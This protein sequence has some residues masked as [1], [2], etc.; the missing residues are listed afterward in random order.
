MIEWFFFD[1]EAAYALIGHG[2]IPLFKE[3]GMF[4]NFL[5]IVK[6]TYIAGVIYFELFVYGEIVNIY[7]EIFL[8]CEL[9]ETYI[10]PFLSCCIGHIRR[11]AYFR[12][13]ECFLFFV[14][15][16]VTACALL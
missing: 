5:L 3:R 16:C 9:A 11:G 12:L 8:Y 7:F 15:L 4:T 13:I 10:Y 14:F 6:V 2:Q 1:V